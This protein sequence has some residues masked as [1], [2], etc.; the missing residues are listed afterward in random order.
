MSKL[1]LTLLSSLTVLLLAAA[2]PAQAQGPRLLEEVEAVCTAEAQRNGV[3]GTF[4][5]LAEIDNAGVPTKVEP[6]T[7]WHRGTFHPTLGYG[8]EEGAVKAVSQWRFE[9]TGTDAPVGTIYIERSFRCAKPLKAV[10]PR[11]E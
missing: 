1:R 2:L 11:P 4:T 5:L 9:P 6:V 3:R 8:L 7:G 10:F